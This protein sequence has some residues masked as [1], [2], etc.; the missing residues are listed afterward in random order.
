MQNISSHMEE[1]RICRY[2]EQNSDQ[3]IKYL[4]H[5]CSNQQH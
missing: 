5:Q 4:I 1:N 3:S 2:A